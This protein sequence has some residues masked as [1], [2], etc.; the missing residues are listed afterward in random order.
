M[1]ETHAHAYQGLAGVEIAAI[2][3]RTE[4]KVRSVAESVGCLA[5][6]DLQKLLDDPTIEAVDVCLPS[7]L[8]REFVVK[9]LDA[10]KHVFC[11]T[12]LALTAEDAEAMIGTARSSDRLLLVALLMRSIAEYQH[13]QRAVMSGELGRPLAVYA[14]RLG[15]YLRRESSEFKEH[16]GDPTIEL[17]T[18]DFDVLNWLFGLPN[19]VYAVATD[20]PDGTPGHVVAALRYDDFVANVEASGLMPTGFPFSVGIRVVGETEC[21]EL[22]TTF[23]NGVPETTL[24]SYAGES[25]EVRVN[26]HDPYMAECQYFVECVRGDADPQLLSAERALEAL[27]LSIAIQDSL[28]QQKAVRLAT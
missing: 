3:G 14:Y 12:P 23:P 5:T 22:S 9:A 4:S 19:E 8:H 28:K 15:S 18:F 6:A 13:I 10:G 20:G 21:L 17:M 16:Y 1:G 26:G 25:E 27:R 7:S 11:E 24:A 2:Y